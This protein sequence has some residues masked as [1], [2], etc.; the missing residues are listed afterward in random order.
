MNFIPLTWLTVPPKIRERRKKFKVSIQEW[1]EGNWV[2]TDVLEGKATYDEIDE[3][4]D[5]LVK[6]YKL[7]KVS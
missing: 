6:K 5:L 7:E 1:D 2:E 4:I 3:I